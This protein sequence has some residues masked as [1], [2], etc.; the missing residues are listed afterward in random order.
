MVADWF[1]GREI[2]TAM[3]I[4]VMSWPFGI[5]MGQVGHTW[6]SELY[7]W[8][9]PFAAASIYCAL[10]AAAVLVFYHA[11]RDRTVAAQGRIK[12]LLPS[13][14]GLIIC[15]GIAWGVFNAGYDVYLGFGPIMLEAQG[16]NTLAAAS[17]ISVGSWLMILSGA[18]GGQ[19]VDRFG[20]RETILAVC[21]T[22]AVMALMRLG[23]A[24]A[25]LSASLIF[26]LVGMAPAGVIMALAGQAVAPE[27]RAFG[28]GVIFHDPLCDHGG[29]PADRRLDR[30]SNR[31]GGR[32]DPGRRRALRPR[33]AGGDRVPD[34]Q[35][36]QSRR[37]PPARANLMPAPIRDRAL[38]APP[39]TCGRCR[40]RRGTGAHA[41]QRDGGVGPKTP[42]AAT[43]ALP[44]TPPPG[45][46][47]L[48][49]RLPNALRRCR[50]DLGL[51]RQPALSNARAQRR[52]RPADLPRASTHHGGRP[53]I[54]RTRPGS[55]R[56]RLD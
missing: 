39:M 51:R 47:A 38:I 25:G 33:A 19:I 50:S 2:A 48:G 21:M 54:A 37:R 27:R 24:V 15:A 41:A 32:R 30:R 1:E 56:S 5:A 17:V 34:A 46:E 35:Q 10:A 22:S 11:P 29:E 12:G 16:M 28:M 53:E 36:G 9:A 43:S 6:L 7:G 18:A 3:N 26:G 44:A 52:P 45:P 4:L 55:P 31:G 13:E 20:R 40:H 14:W 23:T 49:A 8:R 42:A